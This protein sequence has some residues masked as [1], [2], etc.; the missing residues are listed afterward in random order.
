[1]KKKS[2]VIYKNLPAL[3]TE[4]VDGEKFVVS[5]CAKAATESG[6]KAVFAEQKVREK[7]VYVLCSE[8]A[9]SLDTVLSFG[10]AAVTDGSEVRSQISETHELLLSDDETASSPISFPDLASLVRGELKADEAWGIYAA[11][12]ESLAFE[13]KT[14]GGAIVFVPRPAGEIAALKAKQDEKDHAEEYR[15]AFI[16]RLKDGKLNLP[17][18]AKYLGDV[19]AFALGRTDKSRTMHDA[20]FK[21]TPERAHKLLLDTGFWQ[22]TRNPYPLRWGLS[23]KSATEGLASPPDEERVEVAGVSYAI[24]SQWSHDPDDAIAFDGEYLWVHIADP[25]STVL[26]DSTIDKAARARGATLYIPEGASR[27]LSEDSLE[28]YALGLTPKSRALS[29]RIKLDENGDIADCAVLR[30]MVTVERL[31]YEKADELKDTPA[32]APL[33][34]IAEKNA[35]RREK[36]GAVQITMPE[37]HITV[38]ADTKKVS[39][40]PRTETLST[41][42]VREAMILAGEGAARFAFKN[43]IP[44]PYVSQEAPDIPK[45]IPEGLAGQFRL[46]KCMRRRNVSVTPSQHAGMGLGMYSQVTSPLRRYGDL[47]AHEQLRAFLC[48]R[49]LIDKDT[50]LMRMSEGDAAAVAARKAERSSNTHWTLV[51]LLQNPDWTGEAICVEKQPKQSVFC[52]P[53][54]GMETAISGAGDVALNDTITVKAS[55]IDLPLL[56]AVFVRA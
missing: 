15:A 53:S 38:D 41:A 56:E 44:F 50:M 48:G 37:V 2:V 43:G 13:E 26:P 25:A 21:E 10:D 42:V 27:M 23:T 45:D 54:L 51:Y 6:K 11:I 14:D 31:T 19:E 8:A 4:I 9:T 49:P 47:I 35:A 36:A 5:W 55:K 16:Q 34:A 28:D 7:D 30:T 40:E 52:I 18:D 29:F 22:I 24:D 1:M 20:H 39:I 3:V 46:R 32:L 17:E 12:K 33:F